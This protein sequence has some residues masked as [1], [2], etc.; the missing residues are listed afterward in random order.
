MCGLTLYTLAQCVP[1]IRVRG[2][3][4]PS[5]SALVCIVVFQHQSASVSG[6]L[7]TP[8]GGRPSALH[9]R[10][11]RRCSPLLQVDQPDQHAQLASWST[12]GRGT[13]GRGCTL[14]RGSLGRGCTLGRG[15]VGRGSLGRGTLGRGTLG[16]GSL[17]R[18]TLGRGSEQQRKTGLILTSGT[19]ITNLVGQK[20]DG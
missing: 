13:V 6:P 16:C 19:E 3:G 15:T 14:G 2:R 4:L 8:P 12:V 7:H 18:G 9:A 1:S 20:S 11:L 5:K 17:G 10:L